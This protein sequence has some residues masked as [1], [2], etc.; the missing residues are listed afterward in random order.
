MRAEQSSPYINPG[1]SKTSAFAFG[2]VEIL[3]VKIYLRSL[4]Y[5]DEAPYYL[6]TNFSDIA[7]VRI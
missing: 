6:R 5:M 4:N 3:Q 1:K 2:S 7:K